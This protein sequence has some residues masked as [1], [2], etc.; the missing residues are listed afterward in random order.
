MLSIV[1]KHDVPDQILSR[2]R[3]KQAR[4]SWKQGAFTPEA[5][6]L[7]SYVI[8]ARLHFA[9]HLFNPPGV[10]SFCFSN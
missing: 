10:E 5:K 9:I 2:V 7:L 3:N 1:G 4:F 8:H 6:S